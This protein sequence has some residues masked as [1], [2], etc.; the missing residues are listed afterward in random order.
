MSRLKNRLMARVRTRFQWLFDRSVAKTSASVN[1][2]GVP[3]ST[4]WTPMTKRLSECTVAIVTTA[5]VHLKGQTLFDMGD[6]DGDPSYRAIP[7]SAPKDAYMITHDY[8]DHSDAEKDIN[9]VFTIDRL[10]EMM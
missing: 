1:P 7:A 8:Y 6:R 9:I 3:E 4:P 10:R 2:E 5:G